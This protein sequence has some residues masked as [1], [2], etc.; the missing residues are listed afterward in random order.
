MKG[1]ALKYLA[2][3]AC[4][5][6]AT[7]ANAG[8]MPRNIAEA[9]RKI[10]PVIDP[11]ETAKLFAPL[12]MKEPYVGVKVTRDQKYGPADRN[13]LDIF[14]PD[15]REGQRPVLLFVHGGAFTG[16]DKRGAN[17]SPFYDNIALWAVANGMIGVNMTYRLAPEHPYPAGAQD[18][19]AAVQWTTQNIARFGGNPARIFLAGHS[20]GAVHVA[21]YVAHPELYEVQGSGLAGAILVSGIYELT[22]E[23]NE[24]PQRAYFGDDLSKWPERSSLEGLAKSP[25]PILLMRAELDPGLFSVQAEVLNGAMCAMPRGCPTYIVLKDHSHMSEVYSI[26][27]EESRVTDPMRTFVRAFSGIR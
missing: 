3:V 19:A 1:I 5:A 12:Q 21:S 23:A 10:G 24:P 26:N 4:L 2:L 15:K 22:P 13:R 18:V 25:L 7:P 17:N 27:T 8:E 6:F 14:T 20:A 9:V 16:G 11:P